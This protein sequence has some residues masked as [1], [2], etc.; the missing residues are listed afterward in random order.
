MSNL[1]YEYPL[2][3][4]NKQL[5]DKEGKY[6]LEDT[7]KRS[8]FHYYKRHSFQ[9]S[10]FLHSRCPAVKLFWVAMVNDHSQIA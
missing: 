10:Q 5:F 6:F 2:N 4:G 3:P 1:R 9:S 8:G 7:D